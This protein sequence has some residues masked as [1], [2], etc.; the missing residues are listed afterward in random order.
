VQFAGVNDGGHR[1]S[2]ARLR[3]DV[4][5]KAVMRLSD[6]ARLLEVQHALHRDLDHVAGPAGAGEAE[7]PIDDG[8]LMLDFSAS[9]WCEQ[10][11][12]RKWGDLEA[13]ERDFWRNEALVGAREWAAAEFAEQTMVQGGPSEPEPD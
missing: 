1:V 2:A 4:A 12:G 6:Y 9:G 5:V 13:G 10:A 8:A 7:V 3:G 11:T